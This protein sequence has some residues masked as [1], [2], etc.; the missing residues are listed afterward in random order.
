MY[1]KGSHKQIEVDCEYHISDKCTGKRMLQ[2]RDYYANKMRNNGKYIC[3]YCSRTLKYTGRGNPNTRYHNLNDSLFEK[4]DDEHKAYILGFIASDGHLNNNGSI[5]IHIN[6]KDIDILEKIV[7][8]VNID[9][10]ITSDSNREDMVKI[11]FS[12][13]KMNN[14][15]CEKLHIKPGKKSNILTYPRIP[16]KFIY[17]FIRGYF[18]GD[19]S[20]SD[21]NKNKKTYL[22][23]T[24]ASNSTKLIE[25][26]VDKINIPC[27][28]GNSCVEWTCNNAFDFLGKIYKDAT[29]YMNRKYRL[30]QQWCTYVP[31]L[32][33]SRHFQGLHLIIRKTRKDAILPE[34]TNTSDSGYDVTIIEKIKQCGDVEFFTTG[35]KVQPEFGWYTMLVPR[36]SISKTGYMLANG[37]GILDRG[38]MGE[39]IV[40][41]RKVDKHMP[42]IKLPCKIAQLIPQPIVHMEIKDQTDEE[43]ILTARGEKGFGSTGQ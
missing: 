42:D 41:L 12:S 32:R 30:Y 43:E 25:W 14:D 8:Y 40:A 18:D 15:I 35:I 10:P 6:K 26:I 37:V 22:V 33:F 27:Y 17:H 9:T 13:T 7:T 23:T 24:I 38:Y 19:G 39:V 5:V 21:P 4:I 1:S 11:V 36:S 31:G 20:I 34:K 16:E 28:V 29:I 2:Y 3:F